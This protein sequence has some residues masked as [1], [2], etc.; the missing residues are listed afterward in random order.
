MFCEERA[1]GRHARAKMD[2]YTLV[3]NGWEEHLRDNRNARIVMFIHGGAFIIGDKKDHRNLAESILIMLHRHLEQ[4]KTSIGV[5]IPNYTLSQVNYTCAVNKNMSLLVLLLAPLLC[6]QS[7]VTFVILCILV[8]GL[9]IFFVLGLSSEDQTM[10]ESMEEHVQSEIRKGRHPVHCNDVAR[11]IACVQTHT[12]SCVG[13]F[14]IGHSAGAFITST[15]SLDPYFLRRYNYHWPRDAIS[16]NFSISGPYNLRRLWETR[17]GEIVK[18]SVFHPK[19]TSLLESLEDFAQISSHKPEWPDRIFPVLIFLNAAYDF[20]L[21]RHTH[22]LCFHLRELGIPWKRYIVDKSNHFTVKYLD[23][24]ENDTI[25]VLRT[26]LLEFVQLE[27]CT[28]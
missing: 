14:L 16:Y 20:S 1:Y 8:F 13:L 7:L 26:L 25:Q 22:D 6:L 21:T 28:I 15:L 18:N 9:I 4:T 27:E 19:S 5:V 3:E 2:I 23:E 10:G 12:D 11:A 24:K 17:I